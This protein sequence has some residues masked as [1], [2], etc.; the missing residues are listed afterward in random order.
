M[1]C[2]NTVNLVSKGN[3]WVEERMKWDGTQDKGQRQNWMKQDG[4]KDEGQ[5]GKWMKQDG[6]KEA[7]R[8][9][10]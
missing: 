4:R 2:K 10:G 9:N 5:R 8:G 1:R 3:K 7:Q 6:R